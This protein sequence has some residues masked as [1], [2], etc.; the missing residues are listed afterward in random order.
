MKGAESDVYTLGATLLELAT[1]ASP[2]PSVSTAGR[3][4]EQASQGI[5]ARA[6]AGIKSEQLRAF[7]AECLAHDAGQRPRLSRLLQH[8]AL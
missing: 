5:P 4:L 2:Q 8:G 1:G 7:V 3:A 6:I